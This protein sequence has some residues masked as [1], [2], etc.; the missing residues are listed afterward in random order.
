MVVALYLALAHGT[1]AAR[2]S[3]RLL[4]AGEL[5]PRFW[6]GVVGAGL[7]LPFALE[8]AAVLAHPAAPGLPAAAAAL[9]LGGGFLLR[10]V[11]IEAGVKMPLVAAGMLFPLPGQEAVGRR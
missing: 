4:L 8:L 2:A 1:V 5:A 11:V 9:G 3:A 10:L 6:G 7:V